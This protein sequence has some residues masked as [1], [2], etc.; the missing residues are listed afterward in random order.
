MAADAP[1]SEF[2]YILDAEGDV[3]LTLSEPNPPFAQWGHS[4][5]IYS[6]VVSSAAVDEHAP[7]PSLAPAYNSPNMFGIASE[8]G[9]YHEM[10][11]EY[12]LLSPSMTIASGMTLR[13][14]EGS[15]LGPRNCVDYLLSSG[16]LVDATPYFGTILIKPW[17][18]CM[19]RQGRFC[20]TFRRMDETA[21]LIVMQIVHA[22]EN[23]PTKVSVEQ[24]ARIARIVGYT[25]SRDSCLRHY[26]EWVDESKLIYLLPMGPCRVPRRDLVLALYISLIFRDLELCRTIFQQLV[27]HS[28]GPV[29]TLGLPIPNLILQVIREKR[30]EALRI[31]TSSM[32]EIAIGFRDSQYCDDFDCSATRYGL[33]LKRLHRTN[34]NLE[35]VHRGDNGYSVNEVL[36]A[37]ENLCAPHNRFCRYRD[38]WDGCHSN[39]LIS[40]TLRR[41]QMDLWAT[42]SLPGF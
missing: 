18:D 19:L 34:V 17:R 28:R 21:L 33:L 5:F 27:L 24:L 4:D 37:M 41:I 20:L 2:K 7:R 6:A 9:W 42:A 16:S 39:G 1:E 23:V 31:F 30:L 38:L 3:V 11:A 32:R 8:M 10:L 25:E 14:S 29:S 40:E 12:G 15:P 36:A 35:R 13:D 26:E 22:K